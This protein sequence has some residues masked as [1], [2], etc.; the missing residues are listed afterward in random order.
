M[1]EKLLLGLM[2]LL[3]LCSCQ[4]A[5]PQ[6]RI[7]HSLMNSYSRELQKKNVYLAGSGGAIP[8]KINYLILQYDTIARLNIE[9]ARKLYIEAVVGFI[10]KVD[11]CAEIQ[12]FLK[13]HPFTHKNVEFGIGFSD[14]NHKFVPPPYIAYVSLINGNVLY[15]IYNEKNRL[16]VIY[17]EPYEEAFKI[18]YGE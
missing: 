14:K 9:E 18:V 8:D 3:T 10:E 6:E 15:S 13:D 11:N 4:R 7:S 16:E 5:V 17:R 1:K 12:P 2:S